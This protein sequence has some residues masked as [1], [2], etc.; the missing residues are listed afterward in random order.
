MSLQREWHN[1]IHIFS[2]YWELIRRILQFKNEISSSISVSWWEKISSSLPNEHIYPIDWTFI[3]KNKIST[4]FKSLMIF[5]NDWMDSDHIE[6]DIQC[7]QSF[8][9]RFKQLSNTKTN[10][11][12]LT[13][14]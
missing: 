5:E 14:M 4:S 10:H 12:Q 1:Y 13:E 7:F 11:T 2:V 6:I 8:S 3:S 9:L